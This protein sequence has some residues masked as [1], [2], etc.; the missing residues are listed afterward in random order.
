MET[1]TRPPVTPRPVHFDPTREN[2]TLLCKLRPQSL[3]KQARTLTTV[4]NEFDTSQDPT[5]PAERLRVNDD[6]KNRD[7]EADGRSLSDETHTLIV[8]ALQQLDG[9]DKSSAARRTQSSE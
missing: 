3:K 8:S 2:C 6:D 9:S 4:K 1:Q 7:Q 5:G